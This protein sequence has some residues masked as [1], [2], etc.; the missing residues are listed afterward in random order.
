MAKLNRREALA[1]LGAAVSGAA[2]SG[3]ALPRPLY[4]GG[5]RPIDVIV[6]GAGLSGLY[7]AM[8]LEE[9]GL[10]VQVIE[11]RQRVGGRVY[12]LDMVPGTVE[13]GGEAIS[14][15]YARM[16]DTARRL[17]VDLMPLTGSSGWISG[18]WYHLGGE[19][20][21]AS[22]WPTSRQNPLSGEDR[23]LLPE[24]LLGTLMHRD[25]PLRGQSL[26]AWLMPE[27]AQWDIPATD[28]LRSLGHN[29]ATI[30]LTG[31][32]VYTDTFA[33]TSALHEMRRYQGYEFDAPLGDITSAQLIQGGNSRLPEA[34]AKSLK[35]GVKFGKAILGV[36]TNSKRVTIQCTDGTTIQ[37][38]FAVI[39]MPMPLLRDV[40]FEPGLPEPLA[41]AVREMD[42]GLS[43]Q[44]HMSVREPYWQ[45][46]GLPASMWTDTGIKRVVPHSYG[47]DKTTV[48]A[49][50]NGV[51]ARRYN[52]MTDRECFE[53]V[54]A[55]LAKIRPSTRGQLEMLHVQS[56]ARSPFGA[57]DWVYWQ[58]GQVRK[59][60][61][62]MRDGLDRVVF[63]GEHTAIMQ[64]GMEGAFESGERAAMEIISRV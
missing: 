14:P 62:H 49:L 6:V 48:M 38:P 39:S 55:V 41:S 16:L 53:Y 52:F 3:S 57:G 1:L 56:C 32:V 58:P 13:G 29:E 15:T 5:E 59:Y 60:G 54:A 30:K 24:K 34:M 21:V 9:M 23:K 50:I 45:K 63:C 20:M 61:L 22:D 43:I 19:S 4:A 64:R 11:G 33:R 40:I 28:Y 8:L 17:D 51:E 10:N 12:T 18:F 27:F 26:D 42:Y 44:V 46:D 25:S 2:I 36:E 31:Q 47:E 37:A 7:T 35:N